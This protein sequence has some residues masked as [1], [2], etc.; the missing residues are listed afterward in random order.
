M[1]MNKISFALCL[2]AIASTA[3]AKDYKNGNWLFRINADGMVGFL[4]PREDK[5]IFI[6]DWEAKGQ[7]FYNLN[8]V[9]RFGAVYSIDADCVDEKEY[10]HDAF[11]LFENKNVGRAELGL[12]H[13]IAR[14]MGL[15]LPDVG[16]LRI[17]DKSILYK[18]MD[19]NRVLIS[20]TTAT[21]GHETLRLN[22]ATRATEYG[23]YGLSFSSF[24]D[25]YNYA[26]DGAVK[27]K[28][29]HGKLKSAYY[30]AVSYMDKPEN[31]SETSFSPKV[32]ADWRGQV[33]AGVNLQYNSFIWGTSARVIYDNDPIAKTADGF[34]AGTGVSYDLLQSS[35][36]LSYLFS[37]TH[38]WDHRDKI[39]NERLEGDY[40][41]T[42]LA[43]FR[44]KYAEQ[45]SVFMSG[46]TANTELFFA[47]GIRTGF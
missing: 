20:D 44:Y 21:T 34:V 3:Y 37:D 5:P 30:V 15:G 45:T 11:V 17:N 33:A 36:S 18:K 4:E 7:I 26:I 19:L 2:C 13:S 12:T 35:V 46:G 38:L 23:Q 47:V 8:Q 28:S 32:T 22:L 25:D 6:N 29:P 41:N 16:Y 27:I 1:T 42:I 10:I 43:S 40:I 39:T 24:G 9:S 14:K 31:Y